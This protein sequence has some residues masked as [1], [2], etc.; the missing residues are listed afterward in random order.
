MVVVISYVSYRN[1]EATFW[2]RSLPDSI[3]N[4]R[5]HSYAL[6][7]ALQTGNGETKN[8]KLNSVFVN[9]TDLSLSFPNTSKILPRSQRGKKK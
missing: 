5:R 3:C 2:H 6:F 7:F 9:I 8:Y 4:I 1:L